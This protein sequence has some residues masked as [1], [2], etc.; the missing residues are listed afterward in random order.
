MIYDL[1][2]D[3]KGLYGYPLIIVLVLA[4]SPPFYP[5]D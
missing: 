5:Y 1:G 4:I 3:K 2:F